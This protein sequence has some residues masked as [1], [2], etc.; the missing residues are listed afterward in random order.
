MT[1]S[2]A[3][4]DVLNRAKEQLIKEIALTGQ[5]GGVGRAANYAPGFVAVCEA[6]KWLSE[7][8]AVVEQQKESKQ[9]FAEKMRLAR[10]AKKTTTNKE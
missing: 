5:S 6:I 3:A 2:E 8:V 10:E 9:A 1:N 7:D 4:F